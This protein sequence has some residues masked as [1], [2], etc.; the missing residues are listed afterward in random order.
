MRNKVVKCDQDC[1]FSQR[2][3]QPMEIM[4]WGHIAL[5]RTA[6]LRLLE[7]LQ[8]SCE[9]TAISI[10]CKLCLWTRMIKL[11]QQTILLLQ[12]PSLKKIFPSK[13]K[14]EELSNL[15]SDIKRSLSAC[16]QDL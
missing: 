14:P 16:G 7:H 6:L 8:S 4:K 15:S 9:T 5:S 11:Y 13:F 12:E 3:N 1:F 2:H 10:T